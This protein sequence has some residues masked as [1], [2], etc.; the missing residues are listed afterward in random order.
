MVAHRFSVEGRDSFL[1]QCD[2]KP[3]APPPLKEWAIKT[4]D[5]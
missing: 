5:E 4:P 2:G 1:P 3:I